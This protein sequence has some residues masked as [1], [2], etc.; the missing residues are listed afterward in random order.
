MDSSLKMKK[1]LQSRNGGEIAEM[2]LNNHDR[3]DRQS[4]DIFTCFQFSGGKY[5]LVGRQPAQC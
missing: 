1:H 5:R 2:Q 4:I 3:C